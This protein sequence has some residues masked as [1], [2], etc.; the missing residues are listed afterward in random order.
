MLGGGG[1]AGGP[2]LQTLP[3]CS[4]PSLILCW[5]FSCPFLSRNPGKGSL[6]LEQGEPGGNHLDLPVGQDSSRQ[7][8]TRQASSESTPDSGTPKPSP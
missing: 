1:G 6:C 3:F 4:R 5:P 8:R 2:P 7:E